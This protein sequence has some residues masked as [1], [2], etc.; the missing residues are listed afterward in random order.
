MVRAGH[1]PGEGAVNADDRERELHALLNEVRALRD[2]L[3]ILKANPVIGDA[4]AATLDHARAQ[5]GYRRSDYE[6]LVRDSVAAEEIA[7]I[8]NYNVVVA[9]ELDPGGPVED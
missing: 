3:E 4:V 8:A 5:P 9:P 7:R 1:L 2:D 6:V